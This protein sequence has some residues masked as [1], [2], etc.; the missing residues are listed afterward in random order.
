MQFMKPAMAG[1]ALLGALFAAGCAD[2]P[3]SYK[4]ESRYERKQAITQIYDGI[5]T[6]P[7]AAMDGIK[8]Y[9][10]EHGRDDLK[11]TDRQ[12]LADGYDSEFLQEPENRN[13][14]STPMGRY[15]MP[16]RTGSDS[17][18][19]RKPAA[20]GDG[21][22][23][24]SV[25]DVYTGEPVRAV[26]DVDGELYWTPPIVRNDIRLKMVA[27]KAAAGEPP[28]VRVDGNGRYYDVDNQNE[29]GYTYPLE[30]SNVQMV[31]H[32]VSQDGEDLMYAMRMSN[33]GLRF[34][35]DG[36]NIYIENPPSEAVRDSAIAGIMTWQE[37]TDRVASQMGV[38]NRFPGIRF[39]DSEMQPG[40]VVRYEGKTRGDGRSNPIGVY[41]FDED[42]RDGSGRPLMTYIYINP[43]VLGS[44]VPAHEFGHAA[45][46]MGGGYGDSPY[47][48]G[49]LPNLKSIMYPLPRVNRPS[50]FDALLAL[51]SYSLESNLVV[52]AAF[53][54]SSENFTTNP[55]EG[56]PDM[57]SNGAV[58]FDD[59]FRFADVFG[60]TAIEGDIS[61]DG[62]VG[63]DD[64][65]LFADA[66]GKSGSQ[67]SD[68]RVTSEQRQDYL[69]GAQ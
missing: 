23:L 50:D 25:T 41:A 58:D 15:G 54:Y 18:T 14:F 2:S 69:N 40:V 57:D 33:S 53:I 31:P 44:I 1:A 63:F 55:P 47:S 4:D 27:A 28:R 29:D 38:P 20:S 36:L 51:T 8:R 42:I 5:R 68:Y 30:Q 60:T 22:P 16:V 34:D 6:N 66:F 21:L 3:T 56:S 64:F 67:L 12:M 11:D 39:V 19:S 37:A 26:M 10:A 49:H 13:P 62:I 45:V 7:A 59:F 65:F 32:H 48:G 35:T 43:N 9:V 17:R 24:Q 61:N 52:P 46:P